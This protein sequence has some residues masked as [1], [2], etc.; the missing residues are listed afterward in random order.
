LKGH[1]KIFGFEVNPAL[2]TLIRAIW[3]WDTQGSTI[4]S[5]ATDVIEAP[6]RMFIIQRITLVKQHHGIPISLFIS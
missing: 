2:F 1:E 5:S 6:S 4:N 3:L